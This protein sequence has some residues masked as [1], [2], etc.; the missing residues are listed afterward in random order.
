MKI[1]NVIPCGQIHITLICICFLLP[2]LLHFLNCKISLFLHEYQ[3]QKRKDV[4]LVLIPE[5]RKYHLVE[6]SEPERALQVKQESPGLSSLSEATGPTP[7][8]HIKTR[9]WY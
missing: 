4:Q 5:H 3:K 9:F 7:K 2:S 1:K 8:C 6:S